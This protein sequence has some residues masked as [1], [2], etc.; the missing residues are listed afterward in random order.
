MTFFILGSHP[1]LSVAEIEAVIEKKQEVTRS[2]DVLVLDGI[3][4]N[5][6]ALQKRLGGTIKIG[7]IIVEYSRLDE[8]ELIHVIATYVSSARGKNKISFGLSVY[9]LGDDVGAKKITDLIKN[10][11]L[12]IKKRVK[13]IGQASGHRRPVRYVS[14]K[15]PALSSVIVEENELL[16]SGG[17][18]VLFAAQRRILIGQ[19][20]TIQPYKEW[21]ERDYGRPARD[22][23]SGMLP[24]KLARIMINLTG[25]HPNAKTLLDPFC[26]SGTILM[27]AKLLGFEH[28]IGSDVSE[29]AIANTKKNFTWLFDHFDRAKSSLTLHQVS[30]E[31]INQ[32]ITHPVDVIVTETYLGAPRTHTLSEEQYRSTKQKLLAVYDHSFR[33]LFRLLKR[34]GVM[35]V[36]VPTFKVGNIHRSLGLQSFFVNIGFTIKQSF[37]YHRSNQIVGREIFVMLPEK[38]Q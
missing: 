5:L 38:K 33:A 20:K 16:S 29:Q 35:V 3:D 28:L 8:D 32:V 22:A 6:E 14:S 27:E 34:H 24:P 30:A 13:A 11:G 36:A 4:E 12:E 23:K 9:S 15:E 19:T 26:G 18:F 37:L 25:E 1:E 2:Q 7:H 10:L 31:K 21:S 17:E